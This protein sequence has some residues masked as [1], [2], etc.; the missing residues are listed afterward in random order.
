MEAGRIARD[1]SLGSG[2][3]ADFVN[4]FYCTRFAR[5]LVTAFAKR[6]IKTRPAI[7]RERHRRVPLLLF[8]SSF[9]SRSS[10]T[11]VFIYLRPLLFR[12]TSPDNL[13][14]SG[15][16]GTPSP[17]PPLTPGRGLFGMPPAPNARI[18]PRTHACM[19]ITLA[20]TIKTLNKRSPLATMAFSV[21]PLR[22]SDYTYIMCALSE[23]IEYTFIYVGIYY[24]Y[25]GPVWRFASF[26]I[27]RSNRYYYV[28]VYET[29]QLVIFESFASIGRR[30]RSSRTDRGRF[31]MYAT[32]RPSL[33]HIRAAA[34]VL[35][36]WW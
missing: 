18:A 11:G 5:A 15:F 25:G 1:P 29:G 10:P 34:A 8:F 7:V 35:I 30:R 16:F 4:H 33:S 3:R 24:H 20:E 13:S 26:A 14:R 9:A 21:S 17:P 22:L 36:R 6:E 32:F 19:Y 28:H 23:R 31:T 27:T 2:P 12:P